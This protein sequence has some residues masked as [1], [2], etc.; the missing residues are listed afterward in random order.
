MKRYVA[1]IL[2]GRVFIHDRRITGFSWFL[3]AAVVTLAIFFAITLLAGVATN[4][5]GS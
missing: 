1:L 5:P 2:S 4:E 3:L